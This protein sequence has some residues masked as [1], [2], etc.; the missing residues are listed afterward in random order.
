MWMSSVLTKV[1]WK[2]LTLI[3]IPILMTLPPSLLPCRWTLKGSVWWRALWM[4]L[5]LTSCT[6]SKCT[7]DK[8]HHVTAM[9]PSCNSVLSYSLQCCVVWPA[10][11]NFSLQ[12]IAAALS[13]TLDNCPWM[14]SRD[15]WEGGG[16]DFSCQ[17][18]HW[19]SRGLKLTKAQ[20]L[21][22]WLNQ[23]TVQ[24][25][26]CHSM[27]SKHSMHGRSKHCDMLTWADCAVYDWSWWLSLNM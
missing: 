17:W 26:M 4:V 19:S 11:P 16:D 3:L 12:L 22:R 15:N 20:P 2:L 8:W 25:N 6:T 1:E 7:L 27:D 10:R 21:Q 14:V 24:V 23:V 18:F 9:W 13:H 5:P